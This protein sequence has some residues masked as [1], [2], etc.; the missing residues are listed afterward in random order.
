MTAFVEN[1]V[2][3]AQQGLGL[4]AVLATF[5][6]FAILGALVAGPRRL[7]L[8]DAIVGW[9]AASLAFTL[10]GVTQ[11]MSLR[12]VAFGLLGAAVP[13]AVYVL[14]RDG[15]L[16]DPTLL[17]TLALGLPFIVIVTASRASQW[18]EFT[19]WLPNVRYLF[20]FHAFAGAQGPWADSAAPGYPHGLA[21]A[22]Y[23]PSLLI[24]SLIENAC[25]L[26]NLLL[27][28]CLAALVADVVRSA[29]NSSDGA[30]TKP[31]A[32][33]LPAGWGPCALGV[34]AATFLSPTF[35]PKVA[36]TAYADSTTAVVFGFAIASACRLLEALS[37]QRPADARRLA[38]QLGLLLTALVAVKQ[39][40]VVLL[41]ALVLGIGV[42]AA[43]ERTIG[44]RRGLAFLPAMLSLPVVVYVAW[45]IHVGLYLP[46]GE[47]PLRPIGEWSYRLIPDVLAAMA[48]V[49]GKKGGYFL[50]MLCAVA[51]GIR[52]AIW[53]RN[54][55]DRL[56]VLVAV[57]FLVHNAF[58]LFTY[59]AAFSEFD[60]TRVASY[61]RYNMQLG[62]AAVLFAV[63]GLAR[64]AQRVPARSYF[65]YAATAC[66]VLALALPIA[67]SGWL[68]F[69]RTAAKTY[70]RSV[71]DELARL[72]P[73]DA[74]LMI[75]DPLDDGGYAVMVRYAVVRSIADV[76]WISAFSRLTA[77]QMRA[78]IDKWKATHVW[79]HEP[80]D[81]V[82]AALGM[83]L[84]KQASTLLARSGDGW[85][86][87]QSWPYPG[88]A[89]PRKSRD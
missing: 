10:A 41:A 69:D 29:A 22:G 75:A 46:E 52:G 5:F 32:A 86:V 58:L 53:P 18:D 2:P 4:A 34:L 36:L 33:S 65:R 79:V 88:Y 89:Q 84:P 67:L 80:T 73:L 50:V 42:V 47:F 1:V 43:R 44:L 30:A 39:T 3:T 21:F 57:A 76:N 77:P 15:R 78:N 81:D 56:A 63:L 7:A 48:T 31:D 14:R 13:A 54:A 17:R 25:A 6:A 27:L 35:V 28:L 23:L 38:W 70:V 40:T 24:G 82:E 68:R 49:A 20:G 64:A 72:L 12:Y 61:W 74:R 85:S 11:A 66:V 45:R 37:S 62:A 59:V 26:F 16:I 8:A 71:G 9:G 51:F 60:A 55:F 87:R 83:Q 19:N